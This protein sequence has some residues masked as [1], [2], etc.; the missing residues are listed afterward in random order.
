VQLREGAVSSEEDVIEYCRGRIAT[1][2][3]PRY[4][5]FVTDWPMSGT[6]IQ[7]FQLRDALQRELQERQV[8][9]ADKISS[10]RPS[11]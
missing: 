6:K 2:K 11:R 1:Y 7:R 8:T 5:R 3:V 4:V 9:V 10:R